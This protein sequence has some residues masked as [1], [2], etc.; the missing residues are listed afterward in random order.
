MNIGFALPTSLALCLAYIFGL[1]VTRLPVPAPWIGAGLCAIAILLELL[2]AR[3]LRAKFRRGFWLWMGLA[4]LVATLHFHWR[5]PLPGERDISRFMPV[6]RSQSVTVR[7]IVKELPRLTRSEQ[8]QLWLRVEGLDVGGLAE[9]LTIAPEQARGRLYVTVPQEL[10]AD[11]YPGLRLQVTGQLSLPEAAKNPG[12]FDFQQFLRQ[13]DCFAAMR[14]ETLIKDATPSGFGLWQIQRRIVRSLTAQLPAP[15]GALLSAMVLGGRV[16]DLPFALKDQFAQVGLSHALAASGFQVSLIL[17]VVLA[18]TQRLPNRSQVVIGI[19]CLGLFLGLTG[20]SPAVCRAVVMGLAVLLAKW[21]EQKAE[22][23]GALLLATTSLLVINPLWV[24][25][26]GFQFSVL[27]TLGLLVT[28]PGLQA[29]LIAIPPW[30][31]SALAVPIAAFVWT[32]PLQLHSFGVM[33]PYAVLVNVVT[34]PLIVVMSLGAVGLATIAA[35]VPAW[36]SSLAWVLHYPV[37]WL[38]GIVEFA[39]RL[40]GVSWAVG[41]LPLALMVLLYGLLVLLWQ[42]PRSRRYGGAIGLGAA[43][44]VWLPAVTAQIQLTQI[45]A[46]VTRDQPVLVVQDRGR[47]GL[48]NSG[49]PRT[50][51]MTVLPFLQQQGIGKL[52]WAIALTSEA[53]ESDQSGWQA[54]RSRLAIRQWHDSQALGR[55]VKLGRGRGE[56]I[57]PDLL[58]LPIGKS[59]WLLAAALPGKS[60]VELAQMPSLRGHGVLWWPGGK[61]RSD[62]I[63]QIQPQVAI[64]F[65]RRL[66][67]LTEAMLNQ[68]GVRVFWLKR[69]GAV[70]WR[71]GQGVRSGFGDSDA[72]GAWL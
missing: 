39:G 10:G 57:A 37:V 7:G 55:S 44:I 51:Q 67:G 36:A 32:L 11:A 17:A 65:G 6:V 60:Q 16:V 9:R 64:A 1:W 15:E 24:H 35:I 71:S 29:R 18:L 19:L 41:L 28:V 66:D 2:T 48:V 27:A 61:L 22:P 56:V 4:M 46:L 25:D 3:F 21:F 33:S 62:L 23:L 58:S 47:S 13:A 20:L 50:A 42:W 31:A 49:A 68:R 12:G 40:P 34:T 8:M 43:A 54:L 53:A 59:R 45:T 26:L 52:D 30:L 69:D 5:S 63:D 38:L 70:Q 14:G 72:K